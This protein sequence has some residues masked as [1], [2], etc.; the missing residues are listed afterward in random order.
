[1]SQRTKRGF[2]KKYEVLKQIKVGRDG[3]LQ[4]H[5]EA[6]INS[7]EYRA[8]MPVIIKPENYAAWL[9]PDT[10]AN[11]ALALLDDHNDGELTFYRV[12]Q[13]LVNHQKNVPEAIEEIAA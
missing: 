11:D 8:A 6:K 2:I 3:A 9:S 10:A 4:T 7:P 12:S 13:E 1:M 5:R